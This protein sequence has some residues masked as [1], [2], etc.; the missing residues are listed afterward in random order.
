MYAHL[1]EAVTDV[2]VSAAGTAVGAAVDVTAAAAVVVYDVIADA[3][4][5]LLY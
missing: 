3:V 2:Y 4:I 1:E 5:V